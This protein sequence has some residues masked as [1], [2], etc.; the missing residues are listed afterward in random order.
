MFGFIV[1]R[2][3]STIPVMGFVA[4]FVFSLLY[5]APGDPAAVIAGDQATPIVLMG[6]Y[7]PIYSRGVDRFL[8]EAKAAGIDGL[9]LAFEELQFFCEKFEILGVFPADPFRSRG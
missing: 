2:I 3:I 4:L 1:R 7:N 9:A 6:Y 8:A 5:L